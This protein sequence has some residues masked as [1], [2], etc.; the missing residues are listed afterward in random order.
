MKQKVI[1]I[2]GGIAG[3]SAGVYAQKCGFDTTIL[4]SHSIG[5]GICTSWKR[6]GYLFEGG[7]HWLGG[8]DKKQPTNRMWRHIG[9]LDDSVAIHYG[10]PFVEYNYKGTPIRFYRDVDK[11]ERHLLELAPDD[12]K[13]IKKF[14]GNI[15]KFKNLV[16]PISDLKGVKVTK[17][18]PKSLSALLSM[19]PLIRIMGAYSKVSVVQYAKRFTHDGIRE[20]FSSMPGNEQGVAMFIMTMGALAS[21]DAGFPEGGSLP[22][23]QRIAKTFI[24]LGGEMLLNTHAEKVIVENGKA[25]GV[26]S[27]NKT[28]N[29]SKQMNADAVIITIDTMAIDNLF[30]TPPQAS[31]LEEMRRITKPTTAV[32]VSLGINADLRKYPKGFLIKLENPIKISNETIG[33]LLISNYAHDPCYSPVGKSA[34]TMQLPGDTYD[35]WKEL[36]ENDRYA[37]EKQ[38]IADEVIATITTHI[39]EVDGNVEVC[40]VATPLTYERYCGNWKGSWMSAITPEM[41]FK[42]YPSVVKGLDRVYF[43]GQ[44]MIPPGGIPPAMTSGRTAV[45]YLCR[46][47]GTLFISEE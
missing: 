20:A 34:L 27:I 1:I 5:G 40:D 21:G 14:C 16:N 44:R 22:F 13:E 12:A 46:D 6:Q 19:L 31:W 47:T 39:P 23:A 9:A 30:D 32:F 7:M 42:P 28:D 29:T 41:K 33:S 4:E 36:K 18:N 26:M 43:A 17:K 24:S 45:Q 37:K 25:V 11:T 8:S 3:L 15:R 38:R 2:G 35:Y 10:E